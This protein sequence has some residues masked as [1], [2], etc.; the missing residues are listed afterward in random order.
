MEES[1]PEEFKRTVA[2]LQSPVDV[3]SGVDAR[4]LGVPE[5]LLMFSRNE[6]PTKADIHVHHRFVLMVNLQGKSSLVVDDFFPMLKEGDALLVF[7]YQYHGFSEFPASNILW[8]FI[9]F[10]MKDPEALVHLRNT[11]LPL[12]SDALEQVQRMS[13][14]Y[15]SSS[16]PG[17]EFARELLLR[18]G[19][20]LNEMICTQLREEPLVGLGRGA[21]A[22][23]ELIGRVGRYLVENI[24][25]HIDIADVAC[26]VSMSP[27]HLRNVFKKRFGISL[28]RY[29]RNMRLIRAARLIA[30]SEMKLT[31]ISEACGFESLYSFSRT[32]KNQI[33]MAPS[34]Y[35]MMMKDTS[36][37][38]LQVER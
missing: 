28:G 18:L 1:I 25:R 15:V 30:T 22:K 9:T 17:D 26:Q 12:N 2:S 20:V 6:L 8:L 34:K 14:L 19:L 21:P 13:E 33:G 38:P 16:K 7:P 35:R 10:E 31:E 37:W 11:A 4:V 24:Q 3:F 27:S 29:M 23:S 32:F 36:G 5:N